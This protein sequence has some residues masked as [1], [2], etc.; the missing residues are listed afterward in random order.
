MI[1]SNIIGDNL[2][3]GNNM[4]RV[5]NGNSMIF[6]AVNGQVLVSYETKV[7]LFDP[8]T[9]TLFKTA[10]KWSVTTS[11]HVNQFIKSVN[12]VTIEEK[13]QAFFDS[14]QVTF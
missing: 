12:P 3:K 6:D 10:K 5:N 9:K 1:D 13:D 4:K 7:A 2:T 11:K 8:A 14:I